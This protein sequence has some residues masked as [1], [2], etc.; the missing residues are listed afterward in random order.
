MSELLRISDLKIEFQTPYGRTKAVRG[1]SLHVNE[2]ETLALVGESGCGKSVTG[3]SVLGLL[4]KNARV[5]GSI[6]LNGREI[7]GIKERD[8]RALRGR[9]ASIVF[10]DPMT[11]LTPTMSI[12]KQIAEAARIHRRMTRK[13]AKERAL[14]LMDLVG[15]DGPS[16]RY[17]QFP[18]QFSGGMRQRCVFAMALAGNPRL[19]IADEPTT[20]LDVTIQAKLLELMEQIRKK[21]KIAILLITHDLG[22][23]AQSADRVAVMY[24][25]KVAETGTVREVFYHPKH[26]YTWGLMACSPSAELENGRLRTIEGTL[27]PPNA[28]IIGDAFA[29]RNP[30]ALDIDYKQ[31]PPMFSITPT[32]QAA[33]WLL[34]PRAPRILPAAWVQEGKVVVREGEQPCLDI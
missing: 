25:G 31:E 27:P 7:V 5:S 30:F 8:L 34:D 4:C 32:H 21:T 15:I 9:E 29:P 16:K 33:T 17:A 12:G 3:R 13:E 1:V 6:C 18:H 24:G 11:S 26:P 28:E 19:L 14:D 20:A 10:Q 22:V 23:V 2:G